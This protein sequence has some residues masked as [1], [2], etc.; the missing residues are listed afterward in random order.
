MDKYFLYG[1]AVMAL[2]AVAMFCFLWALIKFEW[3]MY[4]FFSVAIPL[5]FYFGAYTIGLNIK[6]N[7]SNNKDAE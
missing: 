6:E 1:M 7:Q 2:G 3:F 4:A 5:A